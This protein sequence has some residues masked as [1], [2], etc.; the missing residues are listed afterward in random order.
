[1]SCKGKLDRVV[2]RR[3]QSELSSTSSLKDL[4][5]LPH[6]QA[7]TSVCCCDHVFSPAPVNS[8]PFGVAWL[9]KI[10][11]ARNKAMPR[12]GEGKQK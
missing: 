8:R 1:M 4:S 7:K 10:Q 3:R 2:N 9:M 11:D 12:G 5:S 6:L